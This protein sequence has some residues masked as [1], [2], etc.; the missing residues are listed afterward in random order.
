MKRVL[1]IKTSSLGDVIH[2]LPA[3]TD[4]LRAIGNIQFDW[5]VEENFSEIA[6]WHPG[7]SNVIPVQIRKWRKNPFKTLLSPEWSEFKASVKAHK[8]D[9]VIDAQGLLKSAILLPLTRGKRY[10]LDKQSAREPIASKFYDVKHHIPRTSHA[11]ERTR[12][13]FAKSLGYDVPENQGDYGIAEQFKTEHKSPYVVL[14]HGTTWASKHYPEPYWQELINLAASN[15]Y[16][17]KLLWG[18]QT[19]Y[20]R[21]QRLADGKGSVEVMP[22]M[23]LKEIAALLT[24]AV[25]SIACDTGLGHLAAAVDCPNV[26]LFTSTNPGLSGAYG[27]GQLHLFAGYDC[28]PCMLRECDKNAIEVNLGNLQQRI[29]PPCASTIDPEKVWNSFIELVQSLN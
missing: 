23:S 10:G 19:E 14:L 3:I 28:A 22:K 1:I 8:Y 20:D 26:S 29:S 24:S 5:V 21:A 25:G 17:V 9:A 6:S 15:N 12:Q 18:N 4:A 16:Q 2:T 7:V 27:E 13:L 11:V